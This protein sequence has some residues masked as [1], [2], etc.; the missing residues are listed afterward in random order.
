MIIAGDELK[1][2]AERWNVPSKLV[3]PASIDVPIGSVDGAPRT[4][5]G[6]G[7]VLAPM[8]TYHA[9]GVWDVRLGSGVLGRLAPSAGVRARGVRLAAGLVPPGFEGGLPLEFYTTRGM[10][11]SGGVP[12]FSLTL[13]RVG[14]DLGEGL[15]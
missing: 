11:I 15:E 7:W 12:T 9:S 10:V 4:A 13:I 2:I 5:A 8:V 1:K 14:T 6:G 3:R